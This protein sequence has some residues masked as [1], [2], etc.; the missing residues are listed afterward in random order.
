M[1]LSQQKTAMFVVIKTE[2]YL[3]AQ[4]IA[5]LNSCPCPV[6]L[7]SHGQTTFFGLATQDYSVSTGQCELVSF[8]QEHYADPVKLR[9]RQWCQ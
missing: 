1:Q 6:S 9:L 5:T 7:V 4:L 2:I 8:S 3:L